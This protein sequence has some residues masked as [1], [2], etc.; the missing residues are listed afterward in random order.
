M[1]RVTGYYESNTPTIM[2]LYRYG[3]PGQLQW[4]PDAPAYFSLDGG[5]SRL[6]SFSLSAEAVR[7]NSAETDYSDWLADNLTTND[8]FNAFVSSSPVNSLTLTDRRE[9]DVLGF[10]LASGGS[11]NG[12]SF[13]DPAPQL[14]AFA[15][16][17]GWSSEVTYPRELADVDGDGMA[18]I[19]GFGAN[20]A[21]VS[22]ATGN[23]HFGAPVFESTAF[24]PTTGWNSNTTYPRELADVNGDHMADIVGFGA[25]GVWV[26][27][28]TGGGGFAAP[29]FESTAFAPTTGW[30]SDV[31]YPRELADVNGDHMAD[32]VAFGSMGVWVSLA[33]GGGGFATPVFESTAFAP[34]TGWNNND[35]YPREL[36]DVNGDHMADIVGFGATGVWVSL[37]SGGGG[38]ATPVFESTAFAPTTGWNSNDQYPRELA[39]ING[40]HMADIVGFGATGVW[41]S[42]ATGNGQF[43][44]P[45]FDLPLLAQ[46]D[47]WSNQTS[48]PRELA[49]VTGDHH[50]DIV[51]FGSTGVWVSQHG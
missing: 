37:A 8:P 4:T 32:I 50:A 30:N 1:G 5:N 26:A 47:G 17:T 39:D 42:L 15:P 44:A 19:V 40:D 36:A 38:F 11:G 46:S 16:T 25:S 24:A 23:G 28:A 27:L 22:L 3:S 20:G 33:T 35:Q 43:A 45:A 13:A 21:W 29:V 49:D 48:F 18:D 2:D 51:G 31:T 34:T 9:M 14:S 41:V 7:N 12:T 6:A 10:T